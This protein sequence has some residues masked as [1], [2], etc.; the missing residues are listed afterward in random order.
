MELDIAFLANL[1]GESSTAS[2]FTE[3][4]QNRQKAINCIFWNAEMGQWLD[5]WLSNSETSEVVYLAS[6]LAYVFSL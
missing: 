4:A 5:Y 2:H 3:A 6:S 1:V